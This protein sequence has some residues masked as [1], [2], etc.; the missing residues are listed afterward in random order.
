MNVNFKAILADKIVLSAY[1]GGV[2]ISFFHFIFL[3]FSMP[4]LPPFIPL[5]NQMPWGQTRLATKTEILIPLVLG[6]SILVGNYVGAS[7]FY[8]RLPLVARFLSIT[9]FLTAFFAFVVIIRTILIIV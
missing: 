4:H 8:Q 1:L 3:L 2:F 6:V 9:G 7:I 5:F